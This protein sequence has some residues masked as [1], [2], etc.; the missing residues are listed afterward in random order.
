MSST[1]ERRLVPSQLKALVLRKRRSR[2][3]DD[4]QDQGQ[5]AD[6]DTTSKP[7]QASDDNGPGTVEGYA[8]V[9]HDEAD[10]GSE[11]ELWDD[12]YG[13]AVERIAPGAFARAIKDGDDVRG[14]VNHDP[15]LVIG[16][17]SAGTLR[18]V[19]DERGLRFEDDLPDTTVGRDLAVNV[20]RGDISGCS[21]GFV[22]EAQSWRMSEM[23]DGRTL[24]VRTIE[25]V[26]LLDVGPVTYPAYASTS[27]A[28]RSLSGIRALGDVAEA[29]ASF[30]RWREV[31]QQKSVEANMRERKL[32]LAE[33]ELAG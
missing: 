24:A 10:A 22:V 12:S 21:F 4:T 29:R 18:L 19:E 30:S 16:R 25:S 2:R 31:Q 20:E 27:V 9:F 8:A 1:I 28:G 32:R 13:R 6:D 26:R 3:S 23:E 14:L 7:D 17:A 11:Y 15:N 5:A 33:L